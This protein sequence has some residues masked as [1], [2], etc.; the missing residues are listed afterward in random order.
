M[1]QEVSDNRLKNMWQHY[2][3]QH[4]YDDK[5]LAKLKG[6]M[7]CGSRV[8]HQLTAQPA[9]YIVSNGE[10]ARTFGNVH[11][12]TPWACPHC[13]PIV[14]AKFGE[15][16]ACAIDALAQWY[17]QLAT[18]ITFTIPHTAGMS[19]KTSFE[20]L[21]KTWRM[22]THGGNRKTF[23]GYYTKS[24]GTISTYNK[25]N[26]AYAVW[27]NELESVH[28]IRVYETTW[29]ENSWHPHIHALFWFPKKHFYKCVND[30]DKLLDQWWHCAKHC[31]LQYF[32]KTHPE[33]KAKNKAF[34]E[35]LYAD[36]RKY[37]KTGHRSLWISKEADGSPRVMK[38]SYYISGWTGDFEM[39][40]T[41]SKNARDKGH[42][43]PH[44]ML[45]KAYNAKVKGDKETYDKFMQL[46]AEY[47]EATKGA[48]RNQ[49]SLSGISKII[50]KWKASND[51]YEL[52]KKRFMEK[53]TDRKPWNV[54][55][56]FTEQQWKEL[57]FLDKF[58]DANLLPT[59]LEVATVKAPLDFRRRVIATY[60]LKFS[61]D[62]TYNDPDDEKCRLIA[63][64]IFEN[65]FL[66]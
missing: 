55:V 66:A 19:C 32:N 57:S 51:Y 33:N 13:T 30:E 64:K 16:I 23:K 27:R 6:Q 20:I 9:V 62:I 47:A 44:Q 49:F 52:Q 21:R 36:W 40:H 15:R 46:Y 2:L 59:I 60:L 26:G 31:T 34:V 11:C 39:T 10:T 3:T 5:S 43:A 28:N 22:F 8:V 18:M 63:E 41:N 4:Y 54:V 37:P 65:K 17:N 1:E 7:L 61:I 53:A 14:M 24:D 42:Y 45:I 12:N 48:I 58:E 50:A 25:H 56:W 29:G 35:E 38:S